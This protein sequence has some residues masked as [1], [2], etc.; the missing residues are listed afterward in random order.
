MTNKPPMTLYV[1]PEIT[2]TDQLKGQS[3]GITRYNS[4]AHTVTTLILRKLG[5]EKSVTQRPLG[6]A[7]EV[8]AAF[9][10]KQLAGM[11]TAVKPRAPARALLNAADLDIPFAMNVMAVTQDF[12]RKN[13]DTVERAMRAYIEAVALMHHD[14]ETTLKVLQKYFKRSDP[15]S[16][17]KCTTSSTA[18]LKKS[19]ASTRATSP[20]RWNS[21][22]SR[23]SM[24]KR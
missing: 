10:Q 16:W 17:K 7:P 12:W 6:G 14:K 13:P 4:T 5:M 1:Q 20:Q 3:L 22:R 11:V 18:T 21:S 8:Q 23:A 15:V 19:R 2:R 24:P 9:E